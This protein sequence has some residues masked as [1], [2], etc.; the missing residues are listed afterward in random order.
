MSTDNWRPKRKRPPK[1]RD[2]EGYRLYN[3]ALGFGISLGLGIFIMINIGGWLDKHLGTGIVFTV[4]GLFIAIISGFRFLYEEVQKMD[5]K[6]N[7]DGNH[8]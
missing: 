8:G 6:S 3:I 1:R 2:S 5:K 7:K 4:I